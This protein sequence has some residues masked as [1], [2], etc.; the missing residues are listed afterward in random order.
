MHFFG[1]LRHLPPV[2]GSNVPYRNRGHRELNRRRDSIM[3]VAVVSAISTPTPPE[4][5]CNSSRP[6]CCHQ[7]TTRTV[8]FV[9]RK[10]AE[11]LHSTYGLRLI[12]HLDNVHNLSTVLSLFPSRS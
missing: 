5:Q 3:I 9:V 6:R 11:A 10:F 7:I 8:E 4:L 12:L 1:Y 2:E